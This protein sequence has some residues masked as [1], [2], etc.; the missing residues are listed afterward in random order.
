MNPL[1]QLTPEQ[2]KALASMPEPMA[3]QII[4][5]MQGGTPQMPQGAPQPMGRMESPYGAGN[6]G[7]PVVSP[8]LDPDAPAGFMDSAPGLMGPGMMQSAS[9]QNVGFP[10][11]PQMPPMGQGP[12]RGEEPF[13][14]NM[15]PGMGEDPRD[16]FWQEG[17]NSSFIPGAEYQTADMSGIDVNN[18]PY[19]DA[20]MTGDQSKTVG[21]LRR[22]MFANQ[23]LSD[24]QMEKA[25]TQ[26]T[27][28]F[29]GNFGGIGRKFQDEEFQVAKRAADEFL[30]VILRKDTGAAVTREEFALYGP[31]Y[32]P[33]PGDK[34]A[35]I[36]AKRKAREEALVGMEMGLGDAG[37]MGAVIRRDVGQGAAPADMSDDD[38]RKALGL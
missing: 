8:W 6:P 23:Q 4:E 35:L 17:R 19:G 33:Q 25:L 29:A 22:G 36:E 2:K 32:L 11:A 13:D 27:D 34:P 18:L 12:A 1:S 31:M 3:M 9:P 26:Y 30:A 16:M 5:Q 14:P 7:A 28:T 24:P 10:G 20:K 37:A 21:Y 38:L 15:M